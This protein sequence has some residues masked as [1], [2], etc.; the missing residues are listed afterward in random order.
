MPV[1]AAVELRIMVG[2]NLSKSPLKAMIVMLCASSLTLSPFR[3]QI[4]SGPHTVAA[5]VRLDPHATSYKENRK[6]IKNKKNAKNVTK[7]QKLY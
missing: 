3:R 6:K 2:H 7:K 1:A 4:H 5:D